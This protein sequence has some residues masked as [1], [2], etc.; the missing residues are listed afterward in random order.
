MTEEVFWGL[1][2]AKTSGYIRAVVRWYDN[3]RQYIQVMP[4]LYHSRLHVIYYHKASRTE[5]SGNILE[6][7]TMWS[8][9][10]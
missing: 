6:W 9:S 3:N 5:Y 10:W 4:L 1:R 8:P 7:T 2:A